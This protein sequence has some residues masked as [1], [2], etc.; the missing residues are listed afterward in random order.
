M[1][2]TELVQGH[3]Q[4]G[5]AVPGSDPVVRAEADRQVRDRVDIGGPGLAYGR[6]HVVVGHPGRRFP[7]VPGGGLSARALPAGRP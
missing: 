2:R 5:P 3:E 1:A 7:H 4:D 6:E